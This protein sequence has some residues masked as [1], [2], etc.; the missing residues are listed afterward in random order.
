MNVQNQPVGIFDSGLGGLSVAIEVKRRLP[1]ERLVYAADNRFCPYGSRTVDEIRWRTLLMA[2]A[3]I[4]R[5]VKLLIVACN[6]A[7]AV[8]LEELRARF[9]VPIIGL[10]PAVKPAIE[11]SRN[12]RIGV[13]ATPRTAASERLERLI[14]RY[15]E[16]RDVYVVPGHGLV[17]LVESGATDEPETHD[18]LRTLIGPL[19]DAGVDTLVL[20]CTHYPFLAPAIRAIAGE[21]LT[22]VDSGEAIARRAAQVLRDDDLGAGG[23]TPGGFE[24][25]TTGEPG[26]VSQVASRLLG[27]RVDAEWLPLP[28]DVAGSQSAALALF[29]STATCTDSV[30][31]GA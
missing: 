30:S 14:H 20:G 19:I 1:N 3:L 21:R 17:E 28:L 5:G 6:T 26:R 24:L 11:R 13:L 22:L 7:T 15:A 29:S 2:G 18:A 4:D 23:S 16:H 27:E 10:E 12:A 25:I 9:S 31:A 8:V